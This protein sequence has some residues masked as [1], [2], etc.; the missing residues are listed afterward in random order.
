[1]MK[2]LVS[3]VICGVLVAPGGAA[4]RSDTPTVRLLREAVQRSGFPARRAVQTARISGA[5]YDR[6]LRS[7]YSR[8][9]P[10]TLQQVEA[11][12]YDSLGLKQKGSPRSRSASRAWYDASQRKLLLR[13]APTPGKRPVLHELVR[14][15]IDQNFNLRRLR[16][17]RLR[18]R[19]RALAAHAIVDGTAALASGL[20]PSAPRRDPRDRFL[21]LEREAGV[22]HGRSLAAELRYLGGGKAIATALRTFPQTTEQLLH[23][24]KFL[25]R[26]RALTVRLPN[27]VG[28]STLSKSETFGELDLR[29]LLRAFG[30]RSAAG[31]AAGWGGGRLALYRLPDGSTVTALVL[32]WDDI[33]EATEWRSTAMDFVA[34]AFPGLTAAD[35]P[36]VDR[37]WSGPRELASA[38]LGTRAVFVSGPGAANAAAQ[39]LSHPQPDL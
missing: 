3:V 9:H 37:C 2:I 5:R 34:A 21:Q 1:M 8:E 7:A 29:N 16:G 25:E 38:V 28:D 35:C 26:E 23:I 11:T 24:D 39:L 36:P 31:A 13:A 19:D 17:L 10:R 27:R 15:L 6:L 30:L 4:A 33:H 32:R 20:R 22:G 18:D 14:A 12:L